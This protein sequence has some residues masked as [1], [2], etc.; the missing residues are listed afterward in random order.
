[1][2][3]KTKESLRIVSQEEIG[4]GIFSMWLQA[5]RMAEAA[6]PG[7]FLSLYTRNGSKLLP[8]P[9]S[10]CEIDRENG[11]IRLVYRV[12]GKN[13]GTE[14][15]SRLHPG[16]TV[17][18]MGPLG[19][20]F[21]L[22]EAEGK[23]V[24]LIGGGIGI[25]PMLQTA[26]KLKA[27]KTAVLGYRDELFLNE[28]F[29]EYA[30]VYVAT[31]DGSAGTKGNVM[32]AVREHGIEADVIYACGPKPMLR[33]IKAYAEEKGIECYISMEERMACGI[34]ACLACVCQSKEV[35]GHSH[36]HNKRVCKDGPV[37]LSTE[38]EL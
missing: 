14:E 25:P 23:K 34:G 10:I 31:E 17:E 9:I 16:I 13:T 38:V 2:S 33:A 32:D 35:D 29:A 26:K 24:F 36:V 22:E 19:N 28:E 37:F 18:A 6:R 21:P 12:T 5:D 15:F 4:K 7:Q 3:T 27:E 1:M 11:R 30:D 20:G 8:R